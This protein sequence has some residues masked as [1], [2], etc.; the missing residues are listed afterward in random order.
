MMKSGVATA[1]DRPRL[2]H[3]LRVL[4]IE[5]GFGFGGAIISLSELV[6]GLKEMDG[7]EPIVLAFQPSEITDGLFPGVR[8]LNQKRLIDYRRRAMLASYLARTVP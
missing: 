8:V 4:F 5:Y 7:I 2:G 3:T 1:G 6:R